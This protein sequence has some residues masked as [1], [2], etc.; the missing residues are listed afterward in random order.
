M[1]FDNSQLKLAENFEVV[2]G[3]FN[4]QCVNMTGSK[5]GSELAKYDKDQCHRWQIVGYQKAIHILTAQHH[6]QRCQHPLS[7]T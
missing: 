3:E 6:R 1:M 5:Y 7:G 4:A 2:I